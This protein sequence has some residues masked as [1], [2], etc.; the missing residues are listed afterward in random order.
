M[1]N[2]NLRINLSALVLAGLAAGMAVTSVQAG[3]TASSHKADCKAHNNCKGMKPAQVDSSSCS[4]NGKC[5]GVADAKPAMTKADSAK[6]A[7]L[8]ATSKKDFEKA[9]KAAGK[10]TEKATCAG[11]NSCKGVYFVGD[12]ATEIACKGQAKCHGLKCEI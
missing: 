3:D 10:K 9:C 12:K 8:A 2:P 7:V 5:G 11:N 4:G 6:A 1:K